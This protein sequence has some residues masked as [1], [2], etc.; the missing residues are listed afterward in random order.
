VEREVSYLTYLQSEEA[1]AVFRLSQAV[2]DS[3]RDYLGTQGF[4]EFLPPIVSKITDPGLRGAERLP[5]SLYEGKAYLTSSM[6]FHK[7]VLATAFGRIYSFSPNVRLEPVTNADSGR[8]LVEFCQLDLEE[9]GATFEDSMR[10]AE[11]MIASTI[12]RVVHDWQPLL[13][14]LG[15]ELKVPKVPFTRIRYEDA[16]K[17]A[18]AHGMLIRFG[19]ELTQEAESKV[20]AEVGEFLWITDYPKKCRSFYYRES[21]DGRT[22][23]SMDL[24]YP[25]GFGEA[26]SGGE[27]EYLPESIMKRIRESNLDPLDFSEFLAMA[28]AGLNPTSGFGIGI[29]RLVRFVT[30]ERDITRVRPFPKTPGHITM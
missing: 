10:V 30:G 7:Q 29:E 16:L 3:L 14:A 9:A 6:V 25:E 4:V 11:E 5:V 8:H 22:V 27:R 21:G 15:R 28:E 13:R 20:S 19:E 1:Q 24:L 2:T 23:R 18:A 17:I 12:A 26:I